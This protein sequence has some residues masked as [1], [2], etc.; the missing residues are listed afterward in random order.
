MAC[1]TSQKVISQ[2]HLGFPIAAWVLH[3]KNEGTWN[4]SEPGYV[5]I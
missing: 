2:D 1:D 3:C 4:N 5:E